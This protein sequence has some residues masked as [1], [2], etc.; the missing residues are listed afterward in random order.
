M[1]NGVV[2]AN[3]G[4]GSWQGVTMQAL[5]PQLQAVQEDVY[6]QRLTE[7]STDLLEGELPPDP[8]WQIRW[9]GLPD[10]LAGQQVACA[11]LRLPS[12][13]RQGRV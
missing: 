7:R 10:E 6:M 8:D 12:L 4:G 9:W 5:Q 13:M 1:L 2:S 3:E 11:A